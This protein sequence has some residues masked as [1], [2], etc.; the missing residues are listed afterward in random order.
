[1]RSVLIDTNLLVLLVVGLCNRDY[2]ST[3]KRTRIFSVEDYDLLLKEIEGFEVIWITSHCI[4]EASNL[5]K[6]TNRN[7]A[8]EL[9]TFLSKLAGKIQG[10]TYRK[11]TIIR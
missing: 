8:R 2:I 1:M 4:A 10:I 6:Q 7:R 11:I 9:L 3:H 5:L